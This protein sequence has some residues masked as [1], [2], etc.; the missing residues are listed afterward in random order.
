MEHPRLPDN[1]T[2]SH[3]ALFIADSIEVHK[4]LDA[5][6]QKLISIL[7]TIPEPWLISFRRGEELI[8]SQNLPLKQDNQAQAQK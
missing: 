1:N 3:T 7:E 6:N 2:D 5:L 4:R 8:Q